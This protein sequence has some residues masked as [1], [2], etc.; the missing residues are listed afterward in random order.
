MSTPDFFRSRLDAMIDMRHPLVVLASRLPWA[1]IEAALA[2]NFAHQNRPARQEWVGDLLGEHAVEF[3]GGVS[4]AGR[5]RLSIRLMASLLFLK[6]SL[7]LSDEELV[8]RW[9]ENVVWQG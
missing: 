6:H 5:P 4:N 8:V 2:P 7:N 1:R 3:G 9:S